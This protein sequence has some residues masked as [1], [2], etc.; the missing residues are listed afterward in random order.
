METG[1][2]QEY[3]VKKLCKAPIARQCG[4]IGV[5]LQGWGCVLQ[6]RP[7]RCLAVLFEGPCAAA[8]VA[9]SLSSVPRSKIA[10]TGFLVSAFCQQIAW[11]DR[12]AC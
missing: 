6:P 4:R 11:D 7:R 9:G 8:Q 2:T 5:G 3:K 1:V 10:Q 12:L